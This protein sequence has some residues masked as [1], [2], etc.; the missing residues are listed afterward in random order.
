MVLGGWGVLGVRGFWCH[1]GRMD[2]NMEPTIYE[3][4]VVNGEANLQEHGK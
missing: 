3:F 1:T 2:K 4:E